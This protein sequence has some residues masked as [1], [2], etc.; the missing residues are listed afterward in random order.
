QREHQQ[1]AHLGESDDAVDDVGITRP[2]TSADHIGV[3]FDPPRQEEPPD[4]EHQ[5]NG[6]ECNR[7]DRDESRFVGDED[8]S[9]RKGKLALIE[10]LVGT[11]A[12]DLDLVG[13]L[14]V[15][16]HSSSLPRTDARRSYA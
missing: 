7:C 14:I 1:G 11:E 9:H 8:T 6:D 13:W 16:W 3:P 2:T 5:A 10:L 15:G 12:L 4:R